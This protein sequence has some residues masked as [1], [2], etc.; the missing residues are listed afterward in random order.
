M[1][2]EAPNRWEG[3]HTYKKP[4]AEKKRART[5]AQLREEAAAKSRASRDEAINKRRGS[6]C[7][8][9]TTEPSSSRRRGSTGGL[10]TGPANSSQD[11]GSG[12]SMPNSGK[13]NRRE[14]GGRT[15]GENTGIDPALRDFLNAMKQ[16]IVQSNRE[17]L[18]RMEE[19]LD[20]NEGSIAALEQKVDNAVSNIG[21]QIAAEVK[22][23]CTP[24]L[25]ALGS[26]K[27]MATSGG[28]GSSRRDE[29]YQRCRRSLK[30]WPIE[31]DDL[32]DSVRVF[33]RNR[34]KM[35][36]ERIQAIGSIA[37]A[38]L[39]NKLARERKEVVAT[40]DNREDRDFIKAQGG[41][42]AG[43]REAGMSLHMPGHLLD[44]LA[45]LNGLAYA[46]KLKNPGLKR[47]VK[48][49]DSLQDVYLDMSIAGNWRK[50]TPA[51]AK[52]ALKDSPSTVTEAGAL[53]AS[54]LTDLLRGR[55][56]PGITVAVVPEDEMQE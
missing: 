28:P 25:A 26:A 11:P 39:P 2:R 41:N 14:S 19:R 54:V 18:V 31:G 6:I 27:A 15:D 42:L 40:F 47:A 22:K 4:E 29:A 3:T 1:P 7:A 35:T 20:K 10:P 55:D 43:Q 12:D 46:I 33:F 48:F 5:V 9:P 53:D 34:L 37:V 56:V 38:T 23:Q 30:I 17:T 36:D 49:D 13:K 50:V 52:L 32:E 24:A 16:D 44:N 8:S 21:V 51:Q 45:A